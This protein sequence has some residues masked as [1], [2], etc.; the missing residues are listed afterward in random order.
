MQIKVIDLGSIFFLQLKSSF[1]KSA[2][3][4]ILLSPKNDVISFKNHN[5]HYFCIPL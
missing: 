4:K 2:K 1:Y 3:R 5:C